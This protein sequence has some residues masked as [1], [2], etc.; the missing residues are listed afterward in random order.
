VFKT[1]GVVSR[2]DKKHAVELAAKIVGA[3]EAKKLMVKLEPKLAKHL[4][5]P[6]FATPLEKMKTDLMITIG[7]DG[8]ILRTCLQLPK[9]EPP[10]LAVN[11]GA[12]GFLAEVPPKETLKAL[13]QTL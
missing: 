3:L 1:V 7:G 4:N 6:S 10:I 11:M 13:D 5:R 12:R 9:P 8:T 2:V